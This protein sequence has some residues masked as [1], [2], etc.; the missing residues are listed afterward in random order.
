MDKKGLESLLNRDLA[1][2]GFSKKYSSW[3][4]RETGALQV[5]DLQ[6]SNFGLKFYLN[7]CCVPDGM[8]IDGLPTPKEHKCPI[9]IRLDSAFPQHQ[10]KIQ[11]VLDLE[12]TTLTDR[13]RDSS[14]SEIVST[15]VLPFLENMKDATSIKRSIETGILDDGMVYLSAKKFLGIET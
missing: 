15:L 6:K 10:R 13:E 7:L 2:K 1:S 11:T 14:M 12:G 4:R 9:R 3:Y 5:V 8:I